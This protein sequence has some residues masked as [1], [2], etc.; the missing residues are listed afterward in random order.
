MVVLSSLYLAGLDF[1]RWKSI[2]L[3]VAGQPLP[4]DFE[5]RYRLEQVLKEGSRS[6]SRSSLM[7]H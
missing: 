1:T 7:R 5:Q 6:L 2:V 3:E 4:V